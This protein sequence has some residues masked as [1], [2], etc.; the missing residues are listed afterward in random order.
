MGRRSI[1]ACAALVV[2]LACTAQAGPPGASAAATRVLD[3][4][5]G[6]WQGTDQGAAFNE[7][8]ER[9]EE[10]DME[11]RPAASGSLDAMRMVRNSALAR[12]KGR[13]TA[14][15]RAHLVQLATGI[16]KEAP[17]SFESHMAAFYAEFPAPASFQHLD[18]ASMRDPRRP[19]LIG[20][21]LADASRRQNERELTQWSRALRDHGEVAP[22][23]W[24]FAD[25][26]LASVD[27]EGILVAA[28]DMDALPLLARQHADGQRRDVLVIDVRLLDDPAY[29]QRIW[30]KTRARGGVPRVGDAFIPALADATERPLFLSPALGREGLGLPPERLYVAG[31]ALRYSSQPVDN[32]PLLEQRWARMSKTTDAGPLSRNYLLP[33]SVLLMHYR[34]VEDEKNAS[35]LEHEV[36]GLA[37]RLNATREL[38]LLFDTPAQ[39][40]PSRTRPATH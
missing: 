12:S 37:R 1:T 7:K 15:D 6:G 3:P 36:R 34:E 18:R 23:L 21:K 17:N 9:L 19:E 5:Q 39:G 26:L 14:E 38:Y 20:P 35:L 29:R 25:D 22:G 4:V 8:Q 24:S 32:I 10:L 16:E 28:G 30:E 2:A 31:L 13:I 11:V 40:K 33:G 27:R